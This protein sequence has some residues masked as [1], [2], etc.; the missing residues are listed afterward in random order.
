MCNTKRKI[1]G[2]RVFLFE[3]PVPYKWV[4]EAFE[5]AKSN[6]L[7]E[8]RVGMDD[9]IDFIIKTKKIELCRESNVYI[10]EIPTYLDLSFVGER[11]LHLYDGIDEVKMGVKVSGDYMIKGVVIPFVI[12]EAEPLAIFIKSYLDEK[13]RGVSSK[14]LE[15]LFWLIIFF[16]D[17]S[18][19]KKNE[20]VCLAPDPLLYL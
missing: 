9:F 4:R 8:K 10:K 12:S 6:L 11:Y 20:G 7:P 16:Y 2:T 3:K 18:E 14:W 15:M 17:F 19:N 5:N 1:M 13:L